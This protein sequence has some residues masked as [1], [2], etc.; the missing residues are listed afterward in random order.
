MSGLG[1]AGGGLTVSMRRVCAAQFCLF[2]DDRR[3]CSFCCMAWQFF[4]VGSKSTNTSRAVHAARFKM[5]NRTPPRPKTDSDPSA[6][7]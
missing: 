2:H 5:K 6:H 3:G 1:G 4:G 7:L